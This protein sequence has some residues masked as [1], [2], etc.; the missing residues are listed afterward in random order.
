MSDA[1]RI[2]YSARALADL[3][4]AHAFVTRDSADRAA[5][6]AGRIVDAIDALQT[7]PYRN[8]IEVRNRNTGSPFR[9]AIVAP[10]IIYYRIQERKRSIHTVTIR[11]AARRRP[12]RFD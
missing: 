3:V 4:E 5:E 7:F 6:L 1:Y 12:R 10:Y 11:H 9:K 8:A 2:V